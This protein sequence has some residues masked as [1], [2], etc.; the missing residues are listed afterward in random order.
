MKVVRW[1]SMIT[2]EPAPIVMIYVWNAMMVASQIALNANK[3][4]D[5]LCDFFVL[6]EF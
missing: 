5:L 2:K 6:V 4:V 1:A 3:P